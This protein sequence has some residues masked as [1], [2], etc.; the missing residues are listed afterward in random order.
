MRELRDAGMRP[1]G[2]V[3][4]LAGLTIGA[5]SLLF[6]PTFDYTFFWDDYHF[7]RCYSWPELRST[8]HGPNDPDGIETP[9]LRPV[10]TLL[11]HVQ[12]CLFGENVR[13]QRGFMAVLLGGLLWSVG[14][15]LRDAGLSAIHTAIV[16]LLF[17]CSRVFA[18]LILWMTLGSLVLA[19]TLMVL[20][21]RL[22]LR[23]TSDGRRT[24]LV[25]LGLSAAVATFTRE[26]AYLL[27]C[28]LPLLWLLCSR[29]RPREWR[30]ASTGAVLALATA[31][32]H[33]VLRAH[34]IHRPP[35]P[36]WTLGAAERVLRS[37]G[38]AWCPGG[39]ECHGS[40]D[41]L[42]GFLWRG[43]LCSLALAA[44]F[45]SVRGRDGRLLSSC[46][47]VCVLGILLCAPALAIDRSFGVALP[48]VAF[49]TAIAVAVVAV[50]RSL[51]ARP[52]L[53]RVAASVAVA[54]LAVGVLAG[55]RRS[56]DLADSM[57][58]NCAS[59]VLRDGRFLFDRQG[60]TIPPERRRAGLA[61]LAA[62]GIRSPA[63]L[64]ELERDTTRPRPFHRNRATR[65]A[66]FLTRYDYLSF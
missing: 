49:S 65:S 31:A 50:I 4:L 45:V 47:G 51:R 33:T 57:H 8:F 59:K 60:A 61:R 36:R 20:A 43:F 9:A 52:L 19:Y 40:T 16:F 25:L 13:L 64:V 48:G 15:L 29:S 56:K 10:A 6:R 7:I 55:I 44:V 41:W 5:W 11:F 53:A 46:A 18:S 2:L 23:W 12:G 1:I 37:L 24:D 63:D 3:A 54:G 30:R 35:R 27:P 42:L 14:L 38:S 32:A 34:F 28:A 22:Y 26:E 39:L 62:V 21:A 17:A 66:F 58:E